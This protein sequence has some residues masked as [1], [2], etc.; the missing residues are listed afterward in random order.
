MDDLI[1]V[2]PVH[3]EIRRGPTKL[4]V[5]LCPNR[6]RWQHGD[7]SDVV[8]D[9]QSISGR[10]IHSA[11]DNVP[12]VWLTNLTNWTVNPK[13]M[14]RKLV[15]QGIKELDRL[16]HKVKPS[17]IVCLGDQIFE[18]TKQIW[19]QARMYSICHPA[20]VNRFWHKEVPQYIELVRRLVT[21]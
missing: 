14:D 8:L 7:G 6:H 5:G 19:P 13:A 12:N 1:K 20:Y 2:V 15:Y 16:C 11:V 21:C 18:Q 10:I 3:T 17:I 4:I 9:S